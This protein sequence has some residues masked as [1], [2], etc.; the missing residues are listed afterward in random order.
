MKNRNTNMLLC[1]PEIKYAYGPNEFQTST[2]Q[3]TRVSVC[4]SSLS[5]VKHRMM[6]TLHAAVFRNL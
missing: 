1:V 5:H 6:K 4:L 2:W 3:L